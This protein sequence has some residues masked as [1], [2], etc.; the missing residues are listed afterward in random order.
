MKGIELVEDQ[1]YFT[2]STADLSRAL[3][4]GALDACGSLVVEGKLTALP[5][6]I[7]RLRGLREL[8]L[9]TDTLQTIDAA[10]FDCRAL[11]R[12]LVRSN[13]LKALPAGGWGRLAALES[14]ELTASKALQGLPDDLGALPRLETLDARDCPLTA[15]PAAIGDA[16]AL[17]SLALCGTR[18]TALPDSLT[19]LARLEHLDLSRTPLAALPEAI[20][21]L[22]LTLL[23]LQQTAITRLPASLAAP[24][25]ELRVFLPRE[26]RPAI[27]ASSAD[28]LAALGPRARFE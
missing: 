9:T 17:R 8:V 25:G 4:S 10:L 11:V 20:G 6:E 21:E 2:G 16:A 26:Q 12:L 24:A 15:L 7:G 13:Q 22:P 5:A 3:A 28:V 19:R 1:A 23:R 27:E 14:L 18:L